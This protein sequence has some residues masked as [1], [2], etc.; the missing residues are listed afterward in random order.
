MGMD[1]LDEEEFTERFP[2]VLTFREYRTRI[3]KKER[4]RK[5]LLLRHI[6]RER[7]EA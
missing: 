1:A 6:L 7:H 5:P 4:K 2:K 3:K